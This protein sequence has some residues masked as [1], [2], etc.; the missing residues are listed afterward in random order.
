M[1]RFFAAIMNHKNL[2]KAMFEEL[3]RK[4]KAALPDLTAK[5]PPHHPPH[6][7]RPARRPLK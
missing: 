7:H 5:C 3:V 1:S 4:L 2:V 6:S